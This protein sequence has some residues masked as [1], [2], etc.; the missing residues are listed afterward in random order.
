M[1]QDPRKDSNIASPVYVEDLFLTDVFFIKGRL[2][3]KTKRLSNVLEDNQRNYLQVQDATLISL[4]NNE[5]SNSS[6]CI[7]WKSR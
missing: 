5:V 7:V 4:R 3:H 1:N 2:A 6:I